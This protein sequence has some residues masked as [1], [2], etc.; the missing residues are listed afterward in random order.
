MTWHITPPPKDGKQFLGQR[1]IYRHDPKIRKDKLMGIL[2]QELHFLHNHF[3]PYFFGE[4]DTDV[5]VE[6][7]IIMWTR[8]YPIVTQPKEHIINFQLE[9]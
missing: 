1:K 6:S 4:A 3:Q 5:L 8:D 2:I 7:D 9:L